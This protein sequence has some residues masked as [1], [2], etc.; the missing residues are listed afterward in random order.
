MFIGAYSSDDKLI[1]LIREVVHW[2]RKLIH[3]RGKNFNFHNEA[4]SL[5]KEAFSFDNEAF[6]F[7][8][9]SHTLKKEAYSFHK[10]ITFTLNCSAKLALKIGFP[11]PK[12]F[13]ESDNKRFN[14]KSIRFCDPEFFQI[15]AYRKDLFIWMRKFIHNIHSK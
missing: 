5:N 11:S 10:D 9:E 15:I 3:L 2:V 14:I 4:H 12:H 7:N 1:N 6:S 13:F 8:A